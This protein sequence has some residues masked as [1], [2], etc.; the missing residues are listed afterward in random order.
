MSEKTKLIL[1]VIVSVLIAALTALSTALGLNSCTAT[2]KY[3]TKATYVQ[4][5]DSIS[6]IST[7][8]TETYIGK[9]KQ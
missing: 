8:V 1:K 7:E 2:R 3:V 6:Q 4:V 9:K 5:G